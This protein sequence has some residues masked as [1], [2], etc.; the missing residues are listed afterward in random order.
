MQIAL[1]LNIFL[2]RSRLQI[3]K[4]CRE[5]WVAFWNEEDY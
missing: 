5:K 1:D 3:L 2:K 4:G